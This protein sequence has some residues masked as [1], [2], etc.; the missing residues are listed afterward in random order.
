MPCFRDAAQVPN[1]ISV[2]AG[3]EEAPASSRAWDWGS[4]S[5]GARLLEKLCNHLPVLPK[6]LHPAMRLQWQGLC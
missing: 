2:E 3:S 5:D 4:S 6:W 1:A